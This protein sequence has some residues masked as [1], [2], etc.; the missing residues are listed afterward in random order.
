MAKRSKGTATT[1][2]TTPPKPTARQAA[3]GGGARRVYAVF[4]KVTYAGGA[5][6][7]GLTVIACDKDESSQ[8]IL[9]RAT[10]DA[11]GGYKIP[12]TEADFRGSKKER[13]GA[14]VVV[15]V[16]DQNHEVLFTSKKQNSAPVQYRLNIQ[17]PA[18][19]FAVW[20]VVKDTYDKPLA[21][22][23]VRAFDQD[24]RREETLGM[25]RSDAQ[26]RYQIGYSPAQFTRAEKGSADLVVRVMGPD[27]K[28][29][30]AKS[31]TLFN[32]P[33]HAEIN[34]TI[35]ADKLRLDSEWERYHHE[36]A[37]LL[38]SIPPQDLTD[39]DLLFLHG[40]TG[41]VLLHL[42]LLRHASRWSVEHRQHQLPT[43]AFYAF[44]RQGLSPDWPQLLQAGPTRWRAAIKAAVGAKQVPKALSAQGEF[45]VK[46][47]QELAV[48]LTFSATAAT[49]GTF[50]R[51]VGLLLSATG[52]APQLLRQIAGLLLDRNPGEDP[53]HWWKKLADAGVPAQAVNTARFAIEADALLGGHVPTLRVLQTGLAKSFGTAQELASI[54]REQWKEVARKTAEGGGLPNEFKTADVYA[55]A[56]A[57]QVESAFPTQSVMYR[58]REAAQP[59]RRD[60]GLFLSL[61]PGF[62]LLQSS[63][64]E[65]LN[66]VNLKGIQTPKAQLVTQLKKEVAVARIVP[67]T[68]RH[69]HMTLLLEKGYDSSAKI[70]LKG[71]GALRRDIV[72]IADAKAAD[73]IY[74]KAKARTSAAVLIATGL[75]NYLGPFSPVFPHIEP[76]GRLA[77]WVELFGSG[78]GCSCPWCGSA[79]GPAAYLVA[80]L[81]FLKEIDAKAPLGGDS[82]AVVLQRRRPDLWHL[83]LDCANAEAP[84]PYI[85]LVIEHL[86]RLAATL[87]AST[88]DYN[89]GT[90]PQTR[91]G[92]SSES[93]RAEPDPANSL[94]DLYSPSGPLQ[95]A[96][97][98]WYLP[99][100]RQFERARIDFEL[101]GTSAAEVLE[102]L[103]S[104]ESA[105]GLAR[106]NL[107][108]AAW[109]LLHNVVV[110]DEAT[111]GA[112]WGFSGW[113]NE[114]LTIA[115]ANGLLK[116]SGLE[117]G[118]LYAL[119]ESPPWAGWRVAI[120]R[121]DDPCNVDS[122][123]VKQRVESGEG[124]VDLVGATRTAVF[125]LLHR[126]LRL[127]LRMGW[128][129]ST[130]LTVMQAMGV[131]AGHPAF[132]MVAVARLVALAKRF[133]LTPES[134]AQRMVALRET[135]VSP[136]SSAI[137]AARSQ[138]LS[139]AQLIESEHS[140]LTA[141]GLP[142][143]LADVD[144]AERLR[145]LEQL[146][147]D[148]ELIVEAGIEAA[149][150]RYLLQDVDLSPPVFAAREGDI[151]RFLDQIVAAIQAASATDGGMPPAG[152]AVKTRQI[153]AAVQL[154][155]EMT[156]VGFIA[157]VVAD[158]GSSPA[159]VRAA[160]GAGSP[161][162]VDAFIDLAGSPSETLRERARVILL[163]IIKSCRLL[164][165]LRLV[166]EDI[167]LLAQLSRDG[168]RWLD[169]NALPVRDG[170]PR[171]TF[172]QIRGLLTASLVQASISARE[173]RLLAIIQSASADAAGSVDALTA[174]GRPIAYPGL[175][176]A[177]ALNTLAAALTLRPSEAGTWRDPESY[178]LL[179]RAASWL[180]QRRLI[181]GDAQVLRQSA[182]AASRID[183]LA[184]LVRRRFA[185]DEDYFK[186]LTPV[187]DRLRVQQRDAL[188]GQI[189]HSNRNGWTAP[190]DVYAHA[191][192]DV[193]M[194]PCQLTSRLVQAHSA[195][196]L[197]VQRCLQNLEVDAGVL[198]GNVSNIATWREW[199][200][201][202]SYRVWEAARKVF[203]YPENWIEPDLRVGK[204]PFFEA[205]ENELLQGEINAD[206]VERTLQNYLVHVHE[207][208]NLDIRALFEE[209]YNEPLADG[210]TA[211]RRVIHMVGRTQARPHVYYY[212]TRH[213]DLSWT[214]WKKIDL[215]IDADHLV[216]A[217]HN[218]RPML[219]WP[220]WQE[221][222]IDRNDPPAKAWDMTLDLS[223]LE[224]GRWSAPVVS[225]DRVRVGAAVRESLSLRPSVSDGNINIYVYS[226]FW[227]W[228]RNDTATGL[229]VE[230]SS[231][232]F[233][234]D[235]CT[236]AI[237]YTST[238]KKR[239][240]FMP[241]GVV[242]S[243]QGHVES[244]PDGGS[245][246]YLLT[247]LAADSEIELEVNEDLLARVKEILDQ[248]GGG[249]VFL[250]VL[251]FVIGADAARRIM[252]LSSFARSIPL[253]V[254]P[255]EGFRLLP[256]Q[257]YAEF[258]DAQPYVWQHDGRQL[259]AIRK[260]GGFSR[261]YPGGFSL[262]FPSKYILEAG[263][264]PYTCELLEAIRSDGVDGLYRQAEWA[265]LGTVVSVGGARRHPRQLTVRNET[266]VETTLIPNTALVARP[267]PVDEFDFSSGGAYALYNWELFFHVPLMLAEQL[268]KN[269][270]YEEAQRWFHTI[271][272][273]TDISPHQAPQKYWRVKPLFNDAKEWAGPAES[274]GAMLRRLQGGN[275]DV[276]EQVEQWRKDPFNP[277][278]LASLRLVA[279]MKT[280]VQKY[281]ENLIEWGDSLFRRDTM[282]AINEATQL[283]V[284][285]SHILGDR[286]VELSGH[287]PEAKSYAQLSSR[288]SIDE[289]GNALIDIESGMPFARGEGAVSDEPPPEP[290]MLYFC[291]PSNPRLRDLRATID[292]RLFKIRHCMDVDGR[293]R[294]LALF[295]P[296]I[297]PALLVRARAAGL[298][299]G[300]ALSMAVDVRPPQYR[301]QSLLHKALEFTN[302]V[303][304]FG[305]ALLSALEKRDGEQMAQLRARHEVGIL[306]L[307]S[308]IKKQQIAEA[309]T[310]LE[311][312]Q[313][314]RAVVE[315]RLNFY[316]TN[317]D[318]GLSA[319]EKAQ[320]DNLHT[321]HDLE[322]TSSGLK[323]AASISHL[324][325]ELSIGV[326]PKV[327]FGGSNIGSALMASAESFGL[328]AQQFSFEASMAGYNATYDRRVDEWRHQVETARRELA[329]L[330]QQIVAGEI[331]LAIAKSEERNHERQFAQAEEAEAMLRDKFTNLQL[332][333]WM[334]GQLSALHYQSYRMAFDLAR[335]AE[336]AA[337]LE[338]DTA[339]DIIGLNHWD[340]GRKGLLAGERLAQDLRRLEAAYM[341]AN[342]RRFELTTHV[343]LRRLN[344]VA[345]LALRAGGRCAF[346]IPPDVFRF[347]FPGHGS[348]RIKSV[349]ISVPGV[350]G[351]YVGVRGALTLLRPTDAMAASR[352]IATSSGQNDAGVFQLDFRDE[353]YLPFEGVRLDE[354]ATAWEFTLPGTRAF[355]YN[356][357][358]DVILHI[359]YTARDA[360]SADGGG[361]SMP[362][363]VPAGTRYQL[364][365]IRHDFPE[366][367][368][369]LRDSSVSETVAL[370]DDLFPYFA[371]LDRL[372]ELFVL[373][374]D[375][376]EGIGPARTFAIEPADL[377]GV[378]AGYVVIE[379]RIA[380]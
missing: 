285:A 357:I 363:P 44:L 308:D 306:K 249:L 280:V 24:L 243:R 260:T 38:E 25:A 291:I 337:N 208:S 168:D 233:R 23:L 111:V 21:N 152:E 78:N 349:S 30:L 244:I 37:P 312:A 360:S 354:A 205:L 158:Q 207:V 338:V 245:A 238:E 344:A 206:N 365:D 246:T 242:P 347:D 283:Y 1:R 231:G 188:L 274:L 27:G 264:H 33:A 377:E 319:S 129:T 318:Q 100:D 146:L 52:L 183:G 265:P 12:Y 322:M 334:S 366:A 59:V 212:R 331:R 11:T 5:P 199:E 292:D 304:S 202:K 170:D 69:E 216:L 368:R 217:V 150:L 356:T 106:S 114:L 97:Y 151:N 287:V 288:D 41:I 375:R 113:N 143:L 333:N 45:V 130:L 370:R 203:L 159:L 219:F 108:Q 196:Q 175:T 135:S 20:G 241:V 186:A 83:K 51:P 98:P 325:P 72:S 99:F 294:Q 9:G 109:D 307:V 120:D 311:S 272:D 176:G 166:G 76:T 239:L 131:D 155:T 267:Y 104:N 191:L 177:D 3:K 226:S 200:W 174:W 237:R 248:P 153:A 204:S 137:R 297:D 47:L 28:T 13:G 254:E 169:F 46:K 180:Q 286:P 209:T 79:H 148:R 71:K 330:D 279:Y 255:L 55:E 95:R 92:L 157:Q 171:L 362:D 346:E 277:H 60:V 124:L 316:Q 185:T 2:P 268:R 309:E 315:A 323:L 116:R 103:G 301:F 374:R 107:N 53:Q 299:I 380:G 134:L 117:V 193:Q 154:L 232:H 258:N 190:D 303:R 96:R 119:I 230:I 15:C 49:S 75:L 101:L 225:E 19:Q 295:A 300:T 342:T 43:E 62:N 187:M 353:R 73:E 364:I 126:A 215:S 358:S 290:S 167:G 173:P 147:Q 110:T 320:Q 332:Y 211:S 161:A 263:T 259:F 4:G 128:S 262:F 54:K 317:L 189:L 321:A 252:E 156:R 361:P 379:Y 236:Q 36:L 343:S 121:G 80:L 66:K 144:G 351:P 314:S 328:I 61:N 32:A 261:R 178:R 197:F 118:D 50:V 369:R 235:G 81:E 22:M 336:A 296:P 122:H 298:D 48:E 105:V 57:D 240:R 355:D 282:E 93:I 65:S 91:A 164:E 40:E 251:V 112:V 256:S 222:Q 257:Q 324:I 350:V 227:K 373:R 278:A 269:Q 141:L 17:L 228:G 329:Q 273:P 10:T 335:Q 220:Q 250:F 181:A 138:W 327:T 201:L 127:R 213:D 68:R 359:Q 341:H 136:E 26:G 194:G 266:W 142:D 42:Q 67:D 14:D 34:L 87:P 123:R 210:T 367:W 56:L 133:G 145:R 39:E 163:R 195:V 352:S 132:D 253:L 378:R 348:R 313:R 63:V 162:A 94:A 271:F 376:R 310:N 86:E 77:T 18:K 223:T 302:E 224:F 89:E 371:G 31:D 84:L 70:V 102:I 340:A 149:E 214:P 125:D 115:G 184:G 29:E 179:K 58:L 8:D 64:E 35:S 339:T 85:D 88:L 372:S 289:F 182:E 165:L 192:I 139:L 82:L 229:G 221:V 275:A 90:T 345:L 305:A 7:A 276:A 172:G 284:L 270:R 326:P 218:R 234:I 140:V 281:I 247:G 198:L 160:T 293:L 16:H 74:Y 6:A